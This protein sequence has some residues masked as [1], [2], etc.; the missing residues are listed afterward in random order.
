MH[1][2]LWPTKGSQ[3]IK[4]KNTKKYNFQGKPERSR[5]WL[6]L[7]HKRLEENFRTHEPDFYKKRYQTKFRGDDT[8][9]YQ[10][11]GV[12]IGNTKITRKVQFHPA[13]PV[14]KHHKKT[15]NSCCFS[16]LASAFHCISDNRAVPALVNSIEESLTL[17][18]NNSK[19]IIHFANDIMKNRRK[20]KGEHNL[21]YNLMIW[22][23][24]YAFDILNDISENVT[25][26]QLMDSIGNANHAISILEH[27]I[28]DSN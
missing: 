18:T 12:P 6:N 24:N 7:D 16:S 4:E 8:K 23:E 28:S 11:F 15:S 14:I 5:L 9:A 20:I 22:K 19:N 1:K 25:L 17:Q 26:V 21:R 10:I 2:W 13:A 3:T 27:C